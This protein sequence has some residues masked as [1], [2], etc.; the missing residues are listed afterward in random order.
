MKRIS[1]F[2]ILA[3]LLAIGAS[4]LQV[5]SPTFGGESIDRIQNATSSIVLTNNDNQ[6]LSNIAVTFAA[7]VK[8]NLR[9]GTVPTTVSANSQATIS[10]VGNIPVDHPGIDSTT[11]KPAA[12]NV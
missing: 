2:V 7:D 6:T 12:I 4:A 11:L 5:G 8:Y 9:N 3:A 1:M 10:V